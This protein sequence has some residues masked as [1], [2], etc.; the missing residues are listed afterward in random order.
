MTA[1]VEGVDRPSG[2]RRQKGTSRHRSDGI[3]PSPQL[4]EL[5]VLSSGGL[6]GGQRRWLSRDVIGACNALDALRG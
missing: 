2:P 3:F 1:P 5:P 6:T 4:R